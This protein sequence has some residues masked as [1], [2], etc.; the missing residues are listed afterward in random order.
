VEDSVQGGKKAC[1]YARNGE[2]FFTASRK[3][4]WRTM[5]INPGG[6][7]GERRRHTVR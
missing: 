2:A 4:K 7:R 6:G 5:G 1:R 3:M